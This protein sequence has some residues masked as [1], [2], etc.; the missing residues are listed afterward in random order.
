MCIWGFKKRDKEEKDRNN[1]NSS[2]N[3]LIIVKY[4]NIVE[5]IMNIF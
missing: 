4:F 5:E 1:Y 2:N 3:K